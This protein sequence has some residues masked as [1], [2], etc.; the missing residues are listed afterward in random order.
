MQIKCKCWKRVRSEFAFDV[1]HCPPFW[2]SWAFLFLMGGELDF[3]LVALRPD[4]ESF[5]TI[6]SEKEMGKESR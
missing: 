6:F 4:L 5:G 1:S 3:L 2:E